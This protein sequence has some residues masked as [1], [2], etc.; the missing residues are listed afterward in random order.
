ML[1]KYKVI[2]I[3]KGGDYIH[4]SNVFGGHRIRILKV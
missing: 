1:Y 4:T 3:K 2:Y